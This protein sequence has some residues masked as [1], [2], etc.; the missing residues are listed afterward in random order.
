MTVSSSER[1]VA[2]LVAERFAVGQLQIGSG[3]LGGEP[4]GEAERAAAGARAVAAPE[5]KALELERGGGAIAASQLPRVAER[6]GRAEFSDAG[7]PGIRARANGDRSPA[8]EMG[9]GLAD[10]Q[11]AVEDCDDRAGR[12]QRTRVG[13]ARPPRKGD[14]QRQRARLE[15]ALTQQPADVADRENAEKALDA[16]ADLE[17]GPRVVVELRDFPDRHLR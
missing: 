15:L 2:A 4:V 10:Q 6:L 11:L 17:L 5:A 3:F 9:G 16:C 12:G 14:A 7:E 8:G 13:N 1:E